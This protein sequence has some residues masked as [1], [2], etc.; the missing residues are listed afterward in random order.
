MV[1]AAYQIMIEKGASWVG[2][3]LHCWS[4]R[5]THFWNWQSKIYCNKSVPKNG[6]SALP[7]MLSSPW[8][9]INLKRTR[10]RI[11]RIRNRWS[12]VMASF[13]ILCNSKRR[14][15]CRNEWKNNSG[16]WHKCRQGRLCFLFSVSFS[17]TLFFS[18]PYPIIWASPQ[19]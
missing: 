17:C 14:K 19:R 12:W 3:S 4:T 7:E 10:Y 9:C 18:P 15:K 1:F 8:R 13:T 11:W 5:R 6:R 16:P 2:I